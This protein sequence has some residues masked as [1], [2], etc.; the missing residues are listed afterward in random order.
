MKRAAVISSIV[1]LVIGLA[2]MAGCDGCAALLFP[3]GEASFYSDVQEVQ[4]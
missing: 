1:T 4:P 3:E 2:V